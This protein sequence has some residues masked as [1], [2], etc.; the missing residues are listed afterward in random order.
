[1]GHTAET[2]A[3]LRPWRG[4]GNLARQL[5]EGLGAQTVDR[6]AGV[7]RPPIRRMGKNTAIREAEGPNDAPA[8]AG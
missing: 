6:L 2:D 3:E 5:L 4:L 1:M 8:A 7:T